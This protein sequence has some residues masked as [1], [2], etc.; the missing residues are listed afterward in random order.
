MAVGWDAGSESHTGTTGNTGSPNPFTWTHTPS[1]T[2]RGAAVFVMWDA[3][4]DQVTSVS[5]GG[6]GMTEITAAQAQDTADE[7]RT[8]A[9]FFLGSGIPTG[10]QTV[11]VSRS[12]ANTMYCV[13]V[14]V[15]AATDTEIYEPGIVKLENNGSLAEQSVTDGSPG[16]NSLRFAGG[17]LGH[18]GVVGPGA[19][20]TAVHSIDFGA[21]VAEVIRET[22]AGQGSRSV[23]AV[24]GTADDRAFTHF[25]IREIPPVSPARLHRRGRGQAVSHAATW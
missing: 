9:V 2:P 22:T 19:N 5:Y 16:T 12:G 3:T 1:G 11:S 8:V 21:H 18:G 23:G 24:T 13:C 6:V 4:S 7:P 15:T 10:A 20:S 17:P 25:A 14:T